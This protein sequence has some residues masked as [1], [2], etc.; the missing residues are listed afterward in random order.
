M[1][2]KKDIY[3]MLGALVVAALVVGGLIGL[4]IGKFA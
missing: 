1:Y 3:R 4:F 2:T